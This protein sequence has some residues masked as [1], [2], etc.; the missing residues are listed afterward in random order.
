MSIARNVTLEFSDGV[1]KSIVVNEGQSVLEAAL[2]EDVPLIYQCGSGSCSSCIV[3]LKEGKA[4]MR[5]GSSSTLIRSEFDAGQ[6]LL[7]LTEP[8]SDCTFFLNYDVNASLGKPTKARAFIDTIE[9][10]AENVVRLTLELAEG[11]W[12]EFKPGQ[13]VQ[14]KVPGLGVM[15]SY[16]PASTSAS[17]PKIILLIR[18]LS[19]GA[20]SNYLRNEAAPDSILELEGPFGSFFLR[21]KVKAPHIMIAGGT[22]LAPIMSMIDSIRQSSGR[23]PPILLSFGCATPD[24]LFCQDDIALRSHWL[25]NLK[26]RISVDRQASGNLLQG[27]PV[28]ALREGDVVDPDTVAY[29][30]GPQPMIDAAVHRLQLLG[31]RHANIF[32][33]QFTP[34]N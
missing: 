1:R 33:E 27:N 3:T 11:D 14:V 5:T 2:S 17:L 21:E 20:M 24:T 34:S 30:C 26:T 25:P 32:S 7:C 16:S 10:L 6:R 19:D 9:N 31:V 15:R 22:G 12:L 4:K 8:E 29:I 28:D 13:F 23:K 18:L